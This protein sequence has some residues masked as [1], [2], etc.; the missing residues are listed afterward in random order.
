MAGLDPVRV[1]GI[2]ELS[3]ALKAVSKEAQKEMR[4]GF[5]DIAESVA[6]DIRPKVPRKT[7]RAAKSIKAR[8]TNKGGSIAFGG[9]R[10][11]HFP[12]LDFGGDRRGNGGGIASRPFIKEGRYV[13][14][15]ISDNLDEIKDKAEDLID[16]LTRKH[17]L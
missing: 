4:K 14:P 17:N 8:G 2:Q 13:Y 5:K 9:P 15:T 1:E 10:A 3:R 7:G 6:A 12:W 11:L 16:D